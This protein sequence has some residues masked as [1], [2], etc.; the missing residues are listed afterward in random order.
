M[1]SASQKMDR[2][3][4]ASAISTAVVAA[5]LSLSIYAFSKALAARRVIW[6]LQKA[7]LPMPKHS[8]LTGHLLLLK[9]L[10][11]RLPFDC[12]INTPLTEVSQQFPTGMG[13]F[14]LWPFTKPLLFVNNTF[15]VLQWQQA[16]FDK[17]DEIKVAFHNLTGGLN[18]FTM[19]QKIWKPWRAVF[20]PAF[21]GAQ[22]LD[23]VPTIVTEVQIFR[24]ILQNRAG[25]DE[26]FQLEDLTLRL[27]VDV[28]AA[29]AIE[30]RLHYQDGH[31]DFAEDLR[32]QIE[33]VSFDSELN[34]LQ[35]YN[36]FRPLVL[37][38]YGRRLDQFINAEL[39]Q[40]FAALQQVVIA[41]GQLG[42]QRAR[43]II[44]LVLRNFIKE[45][46]MHHS[47][48]MDEE[49]RSIASAQ[50]RLFLF[51]GHDTTSSTLIYVYHLLATH[52]EALAQ[53]R[54]EINTTLGGDT[55]RTAEIL[56]GSPSLL[57]QLPY[58]LAVIKETLRLFPPA[59]GFH[60]T[61]FPTEGC[62]VWVMHL[63][64]HRDPRYWKD[65][66]AFI[67]E[68]WLVEPW[69]PLY[70]TKGAWRPFE[71]GPQN[72]LGQS[73]AVMEFSISPAY[74]QWDKTHNVTRIRTV[75]GNRAYQVEGGGCG[76]H[77]SDGYPCTVRLS[78]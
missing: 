70:P 6:D 4:F 24:D 36:P 66:H 25:G 30:T 7:G 51:G 2:L 56:R 5:I 67:P 39:D 10:M 64:L 28:I 50:L 76:A 54:K 19:P 43:S 47:Q 69:D 13:Y 78:T 46:G 9:K 55:T 18:L 68:R 12:T 11:D 14:D 57:N 40:R 34:P 41:E 53:V 72:C 73:L 35:R 21:S 75:Y 23:L 44:S 65:P 61:V 29:A 33:W 8:T 42:A 22:M 62:N 3:E 16:L 74:D 49:L 48:K 58:M 15:A 71:F 27:T 32:H 52:P 1:T 17:P 45:K 60:G 37:L 63:S 77:P 26:V 20:N 59:S 38:Y 31:N